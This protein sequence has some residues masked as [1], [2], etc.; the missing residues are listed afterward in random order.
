MARRNIRI[1]RSPSPAMSARPIRRRATPARVQMTLS[2]YYGNESPTAATVVFPRHLCCRLHCKAC[3]VTIP[4]IT[5]IAVR[6]V[7]GG[8]WQA[9]A[10]WYNHALAYI[11]FRLQ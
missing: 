9:Y 8:N 7:S 11:F 4:F 2:R 1:S 10:R 5:S 6:T 3:S